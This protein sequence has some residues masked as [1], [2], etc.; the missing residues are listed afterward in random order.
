MKL[1]ISCAYATRARY[2]L[3][4]GTQGL[5]F[6]EIRLVSDSLNLM[7]LRSAGA[8]GP[9]QQVLVNPAAQGKVRAYGRSHPP[10]RNLP[11]V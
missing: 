4:D 6:V 3:S 9:L 10:L 5:N 8:Q 1:R 7:R 2:V 11:K